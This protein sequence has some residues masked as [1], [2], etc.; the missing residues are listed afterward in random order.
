MRSIRNSRPRTTSSSIRSSSTASPATAA[1]NQA[2]GLHPTAAGVDVIV[3]RI[4]PK[5]EELIARVRAGK[6]ASKAPTPDCCRLPAKLRPCLPLIRGRPVPRSESRCRAC[7]PAWKSR[8]RSRRSLSL[9]RG[10]L[11][12][13]RWIDPENYHITLRFIGDIDDR[14]GARDRLAARRREAAQLRGALRRPDVVRRAQAARHRGGGRADPAAGG[15]AGRAR[16]A[17]AA[18][19]ARAGG[20]QVHAARHAG[21]AARFLEP[22]RRRLSVDARAAVRLV[23]PRSRASCCSRRAPRSAAGPMWSRRIIRWRHRLRCLNRA[24]TSSRHLR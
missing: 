5:V 1:L 12:G 15:T 3:K 21:A 6:R 19:R 16:A 11:P 9:L 4:L 22:R 20:A 23:V 7:S 8:A 18:P 13:A 2:D 10:G 24:A 14:A 17:D